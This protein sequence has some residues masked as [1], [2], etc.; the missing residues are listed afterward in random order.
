MHKIYFI[1]FFSFTLTIVSAQDAKQY[2]EEGIELA[3][4][5]KA[6]EAIKDFDRSIALNATEFVAW[7]NRGVTEVMAHRY[8]DAL[9]DFDKTIILNPG[10]KKAY[11]NRGT[12]KKHLTDYNGA[13]ADYNYIIKYDTIHPEPYYYRG[14]LYNLLGQRISACLD[15]E[16][17]RR[18]GYSDAQSEIESCVR[19]PTAS[20]TSIHSILRLTHT[21]DN[22]AYGFTPGHPVKVGKGPESGPN[23]V[24]TYLELLRDINGK[25]LKYERVGSCC[26]YKSDHALIGKEAPEEKYEVTYTIADGTSRKTFIYLS[27]YDYEEPLILAGMKTVKS[28]P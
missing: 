4:L 15:F 1:L 5:G 2:Y 14:L 18:L 17:A 25:P 21:A 3:K 19:R 27:F 12:A 8:E 10:Y 28:K 26:P 16:K 24:R 6:D 22:D 9:R 23:N 11:L 7:Y 20:D 13:M